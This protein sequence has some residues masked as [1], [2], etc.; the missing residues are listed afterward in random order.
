MGAPDGSLTFEQAVHAIAGCKLIGPIDKP[1]LIN[2]AK[3]LVNIADLPLTPEPGTKL[4]S[5]GDIITNHGDVFD[6][7]EIHK[8][9]CQGR[10]SE[11]P[12]VFK[13]KT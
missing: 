4:E 13:L 6:F 2:K 3:G 1:L 11:L 7:P 5:F 10:Y 9:C 12:G 8:L